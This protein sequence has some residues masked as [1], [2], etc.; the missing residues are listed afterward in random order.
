MT[1]RGEVGA[2]WERRGG[3]VR[4]GVVEARSLRCGLGDGGLGCG[5]E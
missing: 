3:G 5:F 4:R 1:R 2:Q